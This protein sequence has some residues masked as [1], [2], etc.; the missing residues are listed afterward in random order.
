MPLGDNSEINTSD[1]LPINLELNRSTRTAEGLRMPL[2]VAIA[3]RVMEISPE[4]L[5]TPL[6]AIGTLP[7]YLDQLSLVGARTCALWITGISQCYRHF[8]PGP[9]EC[10]RGVL[11]SLLE[12]FA[13]QFGKSGKALSLSIFLLPN[14]GYENSSAYSSL[15]KLGQRVQAA[16]EALF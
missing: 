11:F 2:R 10:A 12:L 3:A 15:R 8:K 1:T 6:L 5:F 13:A 16:Q 9:L 7:T 14:S 4:K